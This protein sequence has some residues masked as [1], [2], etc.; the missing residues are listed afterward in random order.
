MIAAPSLRGVCAAVI[1]PLDASLR[2]DPSLALPYYRDLLSRGCDA[3]NVLGTTGEAFSLSVDDRLRFMEAVAGS[4]LPRDRMMVGTGAAALGDAIRLTG[5]AFRLGFGAALI[6]PPFFFRDVTDDGVIR[7]F[8]MLFAAVHPPQGRTFLYN[9]PQ[10]SGV[11]FHPALVDRLMNA[12]PDVIAGIK[13][14]SNDSALQEALAHV[15]PELAIF[16]S[17]EAYLTVARTSGFAGCISGS[18]ALW[19]EV[20]ADVWRGD[21]EKQQRLAAMRSAL[22]GFSL[23]NCVRFLTAK[24]AND[25]AWERCLPPLSPL[26]RENELLL[27]DTLDAVL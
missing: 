9:F 18:V 13:D 23:I 25:S 14:S 15:R 20:A 11:R 27:T 10:M 3:L 22:A 2:P 26:T 8:E 16:P 21:E 4:D 17:S 7:F 24:R 6:M 19:P 5:A 1:T 12:F